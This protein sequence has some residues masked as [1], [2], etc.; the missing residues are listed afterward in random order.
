MASYIL[1]ENMRQIELIIW[2]INEDI[3]CYT[4]LKIVVLTTY[5]NLETRNL[6]NC[7]SI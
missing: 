3:L 4:S 2:P 6:I 5:S 7:M 1:N